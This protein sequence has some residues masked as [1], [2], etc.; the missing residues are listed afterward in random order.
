VTISAMQHKMAQTFCLYSLHHGLSDNDGDVDATDLAA[1]EGTYGSTSAPLTTSESS[2]VAAEL[3]DLAIAVELENPVETEEE[4][5]SETPTTFTET[6]SEGSSVWDG[7]ATAA[8]STSDTYTLATQSIDDDEAEV[9]C[10][11]PPEP[12]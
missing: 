12:L 1:W 11:R 5:L 8:H 9:Q 3:I 4:L 7:I 2:P 10:K 6:L